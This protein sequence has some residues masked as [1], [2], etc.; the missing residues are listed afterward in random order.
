MSYCPK[1][2]DELFEGSEFCMNCGFKLQTK[3]EQ[4]SKTHEEPE[5]SD[6]VPVENT[7]TESSQLITKKRNKK[8]ILLASLIPALVIVLAAGAVW[9]FFLRATGTNFLNI[10]WGKVQQM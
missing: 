5:Q 2:G 3:Q 1:C 7:S 10:K 8:K 9:F 6:L 4:T